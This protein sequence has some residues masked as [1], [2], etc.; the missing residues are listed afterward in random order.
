[1]RSERTKMTNRARMIVLAL[2]LALVADCGRPI[3]SLRRPSEAAEP[4]PAPQRTFRMRGTAGGLF[5]GAARRLRVR[6]TN[7][8]R[9]RIS[10]TEL[11]VRVGR[12]RR[13]PECAP[14]IYIRTS[15]LARELR[16][17]SKSDR[18]A[19]LRIRMRRTAPDTCQAAAFP[20]RLHG[21]AVKP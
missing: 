14:G 19:R 20:L 10:V 5:P 16:V 8:Y 2:L 9:F 7:P 17:P 11:T 6:I 3:P 21:T 18:G 12:D 4:Q 1:M 13:Q 15:R